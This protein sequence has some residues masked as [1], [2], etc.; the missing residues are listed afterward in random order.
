[1]SN[2]PPRLDPER[3]KSERHDVDLGTDQET[4]HDHVGREAGRAPAE[5]TDLLKQPTSGI[6][7]PAR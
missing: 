6:S 4:E 3:L 2:Q 5:D 1:M 7:P